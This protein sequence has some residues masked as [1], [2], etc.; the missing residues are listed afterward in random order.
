MNNIVTLQNEKVI[1]HFPLLPIMFHSVFQWTEATSEW[2]DKQYTGL[3]DWKLRIL[4]YSFNPKL[5]LN[6]E[7]FIVGPTL[8]MP[9]KYYTLASLAFHVLLLP[10]LL[11]QSQNNNDPQSA[12]VIFIQ[13]NEV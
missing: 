6:K 13:N 5:V 2:L 9:S 12:S 11:A 1:D 8:N 4:S 3:Q 7:L 10:P